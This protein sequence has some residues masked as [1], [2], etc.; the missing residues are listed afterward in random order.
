M[1]S[2]RGFWSSLVGFFAVSIMGVIGH[3][4]YGLSGHNIAVGLFTPVNESIW[5]HLKLLFFP[6]LVYTAAEWLRY[7]RKTEGFLF[8]RAVGVMVGLVFIPVV[9]FAYTAVFGRNFAPVDML[10]F[11]IAVF[12]SFWVSYRR[13]LRGC[14]STLWQDV[15]AAVLLAGITALFIG[16]TF[17][18]PATALFQSPV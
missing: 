17:F 16:L 18:P 15:S 12:L 8:S 2:E 11:F 7:G 10:L 3:F 4:L 5:E 1:N 9:Y 14:D 13:M 6:F